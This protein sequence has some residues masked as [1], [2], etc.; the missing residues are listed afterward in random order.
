LTGNDHLHRIRAGTAIYL[1]RPENKD[2]LYHS[3]LLLKKPNQP[4]LSSRKISQQNFI[5]IEVT[6][7]YCPS[8]QN[9]AEIWPQIQDIVLNPPPNPP[10]ASQPKSLH[11]AAYQHKHR[12]HLDPLDEQEHNYEAL[13]DS[14]FENL[15][16]SFNVSPVTIWVYFNDIFF[17]RKEENIPS[18]F[19][20]TNNVYGQIKLGKPATQHVTS[21][22]LLYCSYDITPQTLSV[23]NIITPLLRN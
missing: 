18:P 20:Q 16:Y 17:T 6:H 19:I 4:R 1:F 21:S 3:V 15:T 10:Q 13:S 5:S 8:I 23:Q 2:I 11:Y 22:P 14:L 9:S 12:T 7:D